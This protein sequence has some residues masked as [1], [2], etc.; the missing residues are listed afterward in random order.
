M[1]HAAVALVY[2]AI[3]QTISHVAPNDKWCK[4]CTP[5]LPDPPL[6]P[7]YASAGN[8]PWGRHWNIRNETIAKHEQ[9]KRGRQS[10]VE[11]CYTR[12]IWN[13][14]KAVLNGIFNWLWIL[15][16][17]HNLLYIHAVHIYFFALHSLPCSLM[18]QLIDSAD[19][20][21][22]SSGNAQVHI[23]LL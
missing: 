19:S 8:M 21:R 9:S 20:F 15:F 18:L 22:D 13:H 3:E 10:N 16:T 23:N 7:R 2:A 6:L 1:R 14:F 4:C 5:P 17:V 11:M 12:Q